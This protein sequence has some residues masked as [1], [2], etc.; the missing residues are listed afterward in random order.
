[1]PSHA[2]SNPPSP[3]RGFAGR[4][5][6]TQSQNPPKINVLI[7]PGKRQA[8]YSPAPSQGRA[9]ENKPA[10]IVLA[11]PP[12]PLQS[13]TRSEKPPRALCSCYRWVTPTLAS[14][15]PHPSRRSQNIPCGAKIFPASIGILPDAGDRGSLPLSAS[16]SPEDHSLPS[17]PHPTGGCSPFLP[18]EP[19]QHEL[20]PN[21]SL[22]NIHEASA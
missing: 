15:T 20:E 5:R 3:R 18:P 4:H 12:L 8:D 19:C 6:A 21:P 7:K 14:K 9:G 11:A 13:P 16:L 17:Q 22:L 10:L 1:M 2:T